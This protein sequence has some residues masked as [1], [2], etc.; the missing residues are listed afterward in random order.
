MRT[1]V[2]GCDSFAVIATNSDVHD[3]TR[4]LRLFSRRYNSKFH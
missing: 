4:L 3:S 1:N 2:L